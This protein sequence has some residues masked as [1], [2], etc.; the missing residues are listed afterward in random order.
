MS[1]ASLKSHNSHLRRSGLAFLFVVDWGRE[2]KELARF[3][4]WADYFIFR[5]GN[6]HVASQNV[7]QF[8]RT[9]MALGL[10]L[11]SEIPETICC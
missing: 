11:K 9:F 5:R 4:M 6:L 7:L 2:E 10:F 8:A 1:L 3:Q